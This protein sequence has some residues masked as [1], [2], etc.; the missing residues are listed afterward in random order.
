MAGSIEIGVVGYSV[1]LCLILAFVV[2]PLVCVLLFPLKCS[3][4][5]YSIKDRVDRID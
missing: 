4:Q 2:A 3:V 1:G 5:Y